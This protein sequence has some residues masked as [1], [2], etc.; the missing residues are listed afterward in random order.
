[1][2]VLSRQAQKREFFNANFR[3]VSPVSVGHMLRRDRRRLGW[4]YAKRE[5]RIARAKQ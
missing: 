4:M 3:R 1:M 5:F 2:P